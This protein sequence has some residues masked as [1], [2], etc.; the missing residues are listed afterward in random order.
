MR[1]DGASRSLLPGSDAAGEYS[2]RRGSGAAATPARDGAGAAARSRADQSFRRC[3]SALGGSVVGQWHRCRP[4]KTPRYS[5]GWFPLRWSSSV[6]AI[7]RW[8][9]SPTS[10]SPYGRPGQRKATPGRMDIAPCLAVGRPLEPFPP[11]RRL[12][13]IRREPTRRVTE[14]VQRPTRRARPGSRCASPAPQ[15]GLGAAVECAARRRCCCEAADAALPPASPQRGLDPRLR[16]LHTV[17]RA[18]DDG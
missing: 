4:R 16:H 13:R 5:R 18:G 12:G 2:P 7:W 6:A 3:A 10:R 15:A 14:V 17:G 8:A 9:R 1:L 11:L